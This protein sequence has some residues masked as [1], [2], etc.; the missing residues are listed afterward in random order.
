MKP[1]LLHLGLF[2]VLLALASCTTQRFP[3]PMSA[4]VQPLPRGD[5]SAGPYGPQEVIVIRLSDPVV[6]RQAG[7]TAGYPLT[8]YQKQERLRSGASVL[9]AAGGRC[10]I[11]WPNEASSV[12]IF[13]E[14]VCDVGEPSRG[15]PLVSFKKLTRV[16]VLL[17]KDASVGLMGGAILRGAAGESSGPFLLDRTRDDIVKLTNQSKLPC[18]VS[19]RE[20]ELVLSP[21]EVMRLPLLEA[22][23]APIPRDPAEAEVVVGAST[24]IVLGEVQADEGGLRAGHPLL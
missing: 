15:E 19:F 10:E 3:G 8:V 24:V 14:G 21:G 11:M 16:R 23:G 2:A 9:C 18:T 7:A 5:Y 22:G 1:I 12:L 20:E 17:A 13:D 6:V 4:V